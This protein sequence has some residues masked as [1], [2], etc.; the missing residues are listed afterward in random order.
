MHLGML[1]L[2]HQQHWLFSSERW[3]A[4][5]LTYA[6]RSDNGFQRTAR[7]AEVEREHIAVLV[8]HVI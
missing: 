6:V 7:V 2:C 4:R 8:S 5:G 1:S 3:V